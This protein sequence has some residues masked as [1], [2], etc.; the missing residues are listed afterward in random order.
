MGQQK[1]KVPEAPNDCLAYIP[2]NYNSHVPHGLVVWLHPAGGLK[3]KEL[4]DRWKPL[5]EQYNLILLAPKSAEAARWQRTELEFVRKAI[6]DVIGK[7]NIDRTRVVAIGQEAGGG[8][9]Y[10]LAAQNRDLI[11][12]VAAID[13]PMPP[14][15]KPPEAEPAERLAIFTT[16]SK[17]SPRIRRRR[18]QTP[19]RSEASRDRTRF[20]RGVAGA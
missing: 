16:T 4:L 3:E 9:A 13:A 19:A 2:E 10:L 18:H 15:M 20:G 12:G 7:Y 14:G 8:M 6:D 5:C 11:R 1:I 17:K